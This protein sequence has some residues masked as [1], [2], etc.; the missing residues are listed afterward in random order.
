MRIRGRSAVVLALIAAGALALA[1]GATA[2]NLSTVQGTGSPT[3]V[4]NTEYAPA[5]LFLHTH[6]DYAAPGDKTHGGF[7][8]QV[9]VFFDN[10]FK[11][12]PSNTPKC[13]L[14]AVGGKNISQAWAAC[15]PG[16]PANQNAYLSP[17]NAVSGRTSTAPPQNFPGCTL[18]FNGPGAN[19]LLLYSRVTLVANGTADCSHPAT[20]TAGNTTVTLVGTLA[21]AGQPDFGK[22]LTISGIDA[23]PLPLDDFT[24][25][26]KRGS[27]V[28]ARCFDANHL[29]NFKALFTYSG[30]GQAPDT[31]T[32]SQTC[33]V[34]QSSGPPTTKITKARINKKHR[35]ATFKFTAGGQATGFQCQLKRK[36]HKTPKFKECRSPKVYKHLKRGR[37]TFKVRAVGAGGTDQTPAKKSFKIKKRR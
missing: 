9:Q 35:K 28:S 2:D 21:N 23:L 31:A 3:Q 19:Q 4:P 27:Y 33:Q 25:T 36:H 14:S 30:S 1:D 26:V 13:S 15:G 29:W 22:K 10:D 11:L 32:S 20:N 24:A 7:T 37:Y 17:P 6:T 12:N 8:K 18:V 16:A 34:R 5:G